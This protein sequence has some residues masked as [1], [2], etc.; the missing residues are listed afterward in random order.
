MTSRGEGRQFWRKQVMREC[1]EPVA[2]S[3]ETFVS[4]QP[5]RKAISVDNKRTNA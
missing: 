2:F 1:G 5:G 4:N 3:R